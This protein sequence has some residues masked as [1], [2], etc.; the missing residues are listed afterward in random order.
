MTLSPSRS[1]L[2]PEDEL[3]KAHDEIARL[4]VLVGVLAK[5]LGVSS[6]VDTMLNPGAGGLDD[7][8]AAS[9]KLKREGST[10]E[11]AIAATATAATA[12]PELRLPPLARQPSLGG[13]HRKAESSSSAG[14]ALTIPTTGEDQ[15]SS[16][17]GSN[18]SQTSVTS[19][20]S[21][22][23]SGSGHL[24][25]YPSPR[26]SP[27][28]ALLANLHLSTPPASFQPLQ[29][30]LQHSPPIPSKF[31]STADQTRPSILRPTPVYPPTTSIAT[32]SGTGLDSITPSRTVAPGGGFGAH[33]QTQPIR[34]VGL[35]M[36]FNFGVGGGANAAQGGEAMTGFWNGVFGPGGFGGAPM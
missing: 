15:H 18:A 35:G 21:V 8:I 26:H 5:Q 17:R 22:T 11:D 7:L 14:T 12:S 31:A 27:G 1:S 19:V 9:E 36:D 20:A 13:G 10:H 23:P 4:R 2:G 30:G 29:W 3:A 32:S 6:T 16:R 34:A 33:S 24:S 25:H 28:S